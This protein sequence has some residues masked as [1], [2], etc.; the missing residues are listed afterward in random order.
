MTQNHS[1]SEKQKQKSVILHAPV[2][3]PKRV[4]ERVFLSVNAAQ[5]SFK[6]KIKKQI[7]EFCILKL[8]KTVLNVSFHRK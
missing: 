2:L 1:Y 5:H 4:R 8:I 6:K 3:F 7:K